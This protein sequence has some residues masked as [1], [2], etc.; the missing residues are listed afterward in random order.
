MVWNQ[1]CTWMTFPQAQDGT[2]ITGILWTVN[3]SNFTQIRF[4][5]V[6][7]LMMFLCKNDFHFNCKNIK[8]KYIQEF[9]FGQVVSILHENTGESLSVSVWREQHKPY[10]QPRERAAANIDVLLLSGTLRHQV[11]QGRKADKYYILN[12]CRLIHGFNACT[13]WKKKQCWSPKIEPSK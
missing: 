9:I 12:I 4:F 6:V 5:V 8:V 11:V 1:T 7:V 3:K 2:Q 13:R 10:W